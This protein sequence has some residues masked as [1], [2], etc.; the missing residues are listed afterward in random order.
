MYSWNVYHITQGDKGKLLTT[1]LEGAYPQVGLRGAIID[2]IVSLT[3]QKLNEM[4]QI[5]SFGLTYF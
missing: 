2:W 3:V 4:L 1:G 5:L